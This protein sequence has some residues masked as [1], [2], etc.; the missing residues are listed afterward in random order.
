MAKLIIIFAGAPGKARG[1][2]SD[3]RLQLAVAGG[4][5]SG[6]AVLAAADGDQRAISRRTGGAA[7]PGTEGAANS[8]GKA[9]CGLGSCGL[10][11]RG[12][13]GYPTDSRIKGSSSWL[14]VRRIDHY[15]DGAAAG[16]RAA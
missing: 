15:G 1:S 4:P 2:N 9:R 8:R 10:R 14:G 5:G 13:V 3:D 16:E 12:A 6:S 11:G 7:R